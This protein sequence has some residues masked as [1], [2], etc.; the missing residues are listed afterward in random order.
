[1]LSGFVTCPDRTKQVYRLVQYADSVPTRSRNEE[2]RHY[3]CAPSAANR[4]GSGLVAIPLANSTQE[5]RVYGRS[6]ATTK[7]YRPILKHDF[8]E[9]LH[10]DNLEVD[11]KRDVEE[12]IARVKSD[13]NVDEEGYI[14]IC[15]TNIKPGT[16]RTADDETTHQWAIMSQHEWETQLQKAR[17]HCG[18]CNLLW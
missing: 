15:R 6:S 13:D 17:C 7:S 4:A 16:V 10:I 1:M 3:R 11:T 14:V 5:C 2:T 8:R 18:K 9:A 12:V